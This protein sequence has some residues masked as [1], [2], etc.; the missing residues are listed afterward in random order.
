MCLLYYLA[1]VITLF[2]RN[3]DSI[4]NRSDVK[5]GQV[6]VKLFLLFIVIFFKCGNTYVLHD[7]DIWFYNF[8]TIL[9]LLFIKAAPFFQCFALYSLICF[10]YFQHIVND[11]AREIMLYN[12]F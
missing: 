4:P 9:L 12:G 11:L 3:A 10:R 5:I 2:M 7:K 1:V 8:T 6:E